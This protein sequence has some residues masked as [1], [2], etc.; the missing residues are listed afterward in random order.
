MSAGTYDVVVTNPDGASATLRQGVRITG[1][2]VADVDCRALK[3]YF[4]FDSAGLTPDARRA[5]DGKTSCYQKAAAVRVA[6]H[7]DE[8]GTTDYNLALGQRRAE[9][10]KQHLTSMGVGTSKVKTVSYG[11]ERPDDRGSNEAAW[12]KNRRAEVSAE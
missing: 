9:A 5:L 8:R 3:V 4:G 7:A 10:V 1:P 2:A 6:G 12:A 11:E